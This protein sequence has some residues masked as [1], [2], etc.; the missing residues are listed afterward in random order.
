MYIK[1]MMPASHNVQD[2]S[3]CKSYQAAQ[4]HVPYERTHVTFTPNNLIARKIHPSCIWFTWCEILTTIPPRIICTTTY[5]LPANNMQRH[6]FVYFSVFDSQE[7]Q[8]SNLLIGWIFLC[9]L[10]T[11]AQCGTLLVL[12]FSCKGE[13]FWKRVC[14]HSGPWP[15]LYV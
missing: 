7:R 5:Y 9:Y 2:L 1:Y 4:C 13:C 3:S 8:P 12:I 10:S 15:P 14:F 11:E 6:Y